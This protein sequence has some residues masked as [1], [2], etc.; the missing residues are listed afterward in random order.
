MKNNSTLVSICI[1]AYNC[2]GFIP[3]ALQCLLAQTYNNIELI[4]VNDG[5]T[6][7]TLKLVE[8]IKDSRLNVITNAN[9]G[10]SA[11]RNIA[12]Q[13][14]KG[15][16]IIFFD[17]DD[18]VAPDFITKQLLALNGA[19]NSVV[20]SA[21]GRFYNNDLNTFKAAEISS[22]QISFTEWINQ[23]WYNANPMTNPG[24]ALIPRKLIETVSWNKDLT[25][26]D[27]L[28]YFTRVFLNTEKIILNSDAMLYYRSGVSGLSGTKNQQA[29]Q[30]LFNSVKISTTLV[31][32]HYPNNTLIKKSCAN[33]WQSIVYELYP[34]QG[35]LVKLAEQNIEKLGGSD[36]TFPAGGYSRL[37][38]YFIGWRA[39]K[40]IKTLLL[41]W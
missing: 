2:E 8:S 26:N 15:Q 29:Y 3:Q 33:M 32:N 30:S 22:G 13:R 36:L 16:N 20:L 17:A 31:L 28:E 19:D 38:S 18:W 35:H 23:Y 41:A 25:L 11:A 5:S 24:R 37:L 10:A 12:F 7:G 6:D 27:D 1:P 40:K 4:V 9:R 21:W 34:R 14:S 39:A